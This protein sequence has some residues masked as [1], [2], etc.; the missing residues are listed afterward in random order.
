[1]RE[2][3][4][5]C[6]GP[7]FPPVC[8]FLF[9]GQGQIELFRQGLATQQVSPAG[10]GFPPPVSTAGMCRNFSSNPGRNLSSPLFLPPLL[11]TDLLFRFPLT[12]F[13][14]TLRR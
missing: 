12:F 9:G 8:R 11:K 2:L 7:L 6:D 4:F 10:V 14:V 3:F 13:G 5:Y 1:V